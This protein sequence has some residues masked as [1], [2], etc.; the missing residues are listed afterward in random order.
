MN[1]RGDSGVGDIVT[2]FGDVFVVGTFGITVIV[3]VVGLHTTHSYIR[4]LASKSRAPV[5]LHIHFGLCGCFTD[6]RP[7]KGFTVISMGLILAQLIVFLMSYVLC[8]MYGYSK[9]SSRLL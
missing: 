4:C 7:C 9:V 5:C 6:M 1:P 3:P 8:L 2:F